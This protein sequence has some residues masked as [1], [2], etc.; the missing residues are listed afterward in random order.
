MRKGNWALTMVVMPVLALS[1][2]GDSGAE[3]PVAAAEIMWRTASTT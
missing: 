1:A 2:C 3:V